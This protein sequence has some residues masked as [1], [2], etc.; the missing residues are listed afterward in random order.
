M[1]IPCIVHIG[2]YNT[3]NIVH[4]LRIVHIR[5]RSISAIVQILC[6]VHILYP[7]TLYT[8]T[9]TL[10]HES[11]TCTYCGQCV[12]VT[13]THR[14]RT[15]LPTNCGHTMHCV[16]VHMHTVYSYQ[17]TVYKLCVVHT[18]IYTQHTLTNH[19]ILHILRIVHML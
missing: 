11:Y 14:T 7:C 2:R 17:P 19:G 15:L 6:L 8:Y 1:Y 4:M 13:H 10:T 9:C 5:I 18:F 16:Y 3:C 12:C